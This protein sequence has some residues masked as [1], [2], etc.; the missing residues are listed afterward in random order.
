M[1]TYPL[2]IL[3]VHNAYQHRGGEDAV[4][5]SEVRLLREHGHVV[6]TYVRSNGD[7]A[8]MSPVQLAADTLWSRR[9]C[10]EIETLLG[11]FRPQV[12]HAHNTFPLISPALFWTAHRHGVA[13]VQTLHNFRL[14]CLGGLL[15]RDGA[16][17]E[18]CV[19]KAPWRGVVRKCYR[20]SAAQSAASASTMVLHRR[21]GTYQDHVNRYIALND[22]CRDKFI[23]G[24]LPAHRLVVKPNFVEEP[25]PAQQ[26]ARRGFLYVGRLAPEKGVTIL[27]VAARNCDVELRVA[28]TG[29]CADEFGGMPNATLLG[30]LAAQQ[31]R[32]E[33]GSALAVVVPSIWY[34]NF[35]R[36]IVEAFAT[37][38]PVIASRIGALASLVE[39]GKT[40]LL[41]Q[42]GDPGDLQQKL[43]WAR[44]NPLAMAEMGQAA[45]RQYLE[46]YSPGVNHAQLL[47]IYR[48]AIADMA[49]PVR[50]PAL[51]VGRSDAV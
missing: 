19:G 47:A 11:D 8:S 10:R 48:E 3:A 46:K 37:A 26:R 51:Q 29:P 34:E 4:F 9:T 31:V 27:A 40:G 35:P 7:A 14:M 24:G 25:E 2:R 38:T 13:T 41:F 20:G 23:E 45:R 17:C 5:E 1:A 30:G 15:M 39:D 42:P 28:G 21:L 36:T 22:F 32:E 43:D 12:L 6:Q 33:M 16:I 49:R 50:E 44:A 18:D